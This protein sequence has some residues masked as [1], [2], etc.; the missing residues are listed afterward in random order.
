MVTMG[1]EAEKEAPYEEAWTSYG[2]MILTPIV[3]GAVSSLALVLMAAAPIFFPM[4]WDAPVVYMNIGVYWGTAFVFALPITALCGI[5]THN[6]CWNLGWRKPW[7]YVAGAI[8]Y[9]LMGGTLLGGL[10]NPMFY[11]ISSVVVGVSGGLSFH[12][13]AYRSREDATSP[14]RSRHP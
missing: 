4:G 13:V 2:R 5:I 7:Q 8:V 10:K 6:A 14:P 11:V 12:W 3:S 9:A 1:E